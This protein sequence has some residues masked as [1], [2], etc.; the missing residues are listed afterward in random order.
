MARPAFASRVLSAATLALP[1]AG[2]VIFT[3]LLGGTFW[4]LLGSDRILL[5]HCL[6]FAAIL[7]PA[8]R[9]LIA[10]ICLAR[11]RHR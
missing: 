3:A 1:L 4:V 2:Y 6:T 11:Y 7:V 10:P 8:T 9:I 5:W